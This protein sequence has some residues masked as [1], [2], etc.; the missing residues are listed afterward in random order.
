MI[1]LDFTNVQF[2]AFINKLINFFGVGLALY[3]VAA[4]YDLSGTKSDR[5]IKHMVKCKY[6]RKKISSRVN[7][8]PFHVIP[9]L[10]FYVFFCGGS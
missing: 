6:C 8:L 10:A 7:Q 9:S 2:R 4:L 5:I 3:L 1:S